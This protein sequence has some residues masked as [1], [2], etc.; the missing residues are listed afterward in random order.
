MKRVLFIVV[1]LVLLSVLIL[2]GCEPAPPPPVG[3]EVSS[4]VICHT[5]EDLLQETVSEVE[6]AVSEETSGEG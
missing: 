4:C 3:E 1:S 5:D 6:E 2:A